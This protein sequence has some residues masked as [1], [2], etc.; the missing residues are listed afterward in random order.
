MKTAVLFGRPS[1]QILLYVESGGVDLIIMSSHGRS[2]IARWSM[3]STA[4]KVFK[5]SG[6]PVIVVRAEEPPEPTR[7]F[8]RIVVPLDGSEKSAAVLPHVRKL[9]EVLPCEVIPV[10]VVEGGKHVRTIGG[11][12]YVRFP[13][14]DMNVGESCDEGIP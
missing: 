5:R 6:I 12:D 10:A 1:D 2:G 9:A 3:G 4:D 13:E 11:L 7:L 8:S 14:Q